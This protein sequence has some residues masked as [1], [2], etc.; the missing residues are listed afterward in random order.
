[1]PKLTLE[2]LD[3]LEPLGFLSEHF[4]IVHHFDKK[5]KASISEHRRY[6][7]NVLKNTGTFR[8]DTNPKV[9]ER[10]ELILKS[11]KAMPLLSLQ[12]PASFI[13]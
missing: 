7:R 4:R 12:S 13:V 3:Q 8:T 9:R 2:L 5:K 11:F 6:C 10:L 1:M